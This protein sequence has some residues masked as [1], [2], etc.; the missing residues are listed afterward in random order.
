MRCRLVLISNRRGSLP[1]AICVES[2]KRSR[3]TFWRRWSV[4]HMT[5]RSPPTKVSGPNYCVKSSR[6]LAAWSCNRQV[7]RACDFRRRENTL[8]SAPPTVP[9]MRKHKRECQ[10]PAT[11]WPAQL[12]MFAWYCCRVGATIWSNWAVRCDRTPMT[13]CM[14]MRNCLLTCK[15]EP[16]FYDIRI[17]GRS[18]TTTS[19]ELLEAFHIGK[20]FR[21]RHAFPDA[22]CRPACQKRNRIRGFGDHTGR[23]CNL[24]GFATL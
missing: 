3:G 11:L 2:W 6:C 23:R 13:E 24:G 19:H 12:S 20:T 22:A 8:A 16:R 18:N 17:L 5:G 15:C 21:W 9:F 10:N 4:P 1:S 7:W 14:A